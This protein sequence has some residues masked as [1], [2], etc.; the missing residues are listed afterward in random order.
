MEI[1]NLLNKLGYDPAR[2]EKTE[3]D[4]AKARKDKAAAKAKGGDKV[5]LSDE[6]RLRTEAFQ[7]A[8]SAPEVRR[9]KVEA[10][11]AKVAAGEYEIDNQ[12]IAENLVKDDLDL[13]I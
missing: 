6:A 7:E 2:I 11:K 3:A 12:K 9:E 5:S 1:K 4:A 8:Q 10:I 13:I